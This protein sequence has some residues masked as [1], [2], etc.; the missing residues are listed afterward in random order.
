MV[1]LAVVARHRRKTLFPGADDQS[2]VKIK[3]RQ[4]NRPFGSQEA[5]SSTPTSSQQ[6]HD[7]WKEGMTQMEMRRVRAENMFSRLTLFYQDGHSN[8]SDEGRDKDDRALCLLRGE[9]QYIFD[10]AGKR[11]LDCVNNVAHIGHSHPVL[12]QAAHAQLQAI[13]TNTRYHHPG[14]SRYAKKLLGL[15]PPDLDT[16]FFVNS[17][18]EANDL[19]LALSR[20]YTGHEDVVVLDYAYHGHTG[21][22]IDISPY[23]HHGNSSLPSSSS[24][25]PPSSPAIAPEEKG[26]EDER[27]HGHTSS[28]SS[29]PKKWVHVIPSPDTY[30]GPFTTTAAYVSHSSTL[31]DAAISPPSLPSRHIAAFFAEGVLACGGQVVLPP[32]YLRGMYSYIRSKGGLCIADEVQTGFGRSGSHMW[33]YE[34][35]GVIPDIITLGKPIANGFPLAAVITRKE[36][37]ES[38]P[39]SYFN[40]FGGSNLAMALG[41]ATLDVVLKEKLQQKAERLGTMLRAMLEGLAQKHPLVGDVR[42]LGMMLGVELV[43]DKEAKTPAPAAA[44]YVLERARQMGV[45]I[46]VDGR[47]ENVLKI[48]PPLAFT[49]ADSHTLVETIDK[50]LTEFEHKPEEGE[51]KKEK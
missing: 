19:A 29:F 13:N 47:W 42:G 33:A 15:F 18:S 21:T 27:K 3:N 4:F 34:A 36:I 2:E 43:E 28:S 24:S 45:H 11:Y 30:R 46:Q 5:E 6:P 20:A 50:A 44:A 35:Q 25:S 9:G 40:T 26:G 16:V 22:M 10:E 23:K 14:R 12:V 7:P 48:K 37:A 31:L 51:M 49:E 17:G 1:A 39:H 8:S 32:D 38:L 41:E